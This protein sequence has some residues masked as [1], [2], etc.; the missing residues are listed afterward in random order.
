[1]Q[2]EGGYVCGEDE[3][4]RLKRLMWPDPNNHIPSLDV[5]AKPASHIANLA[6][7]SVPEGCGFLIVEET[8]V[9]EQYPFSGEKLSSVLTLYKYEGAIDNA[10]DQV[11]VITDYQGQGHTCGIHTSSDENALSLALRSKTGRVLINQNLNEGAGSL[12]NGLPY[13]LSLSCGT[14]GG[15]ITTE[16]V[17]ARHMVNLT[18]VSRPLKPRALDENELFSAHWEKYQR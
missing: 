10:I 9:G 5:I 4:A 1:L 15:N 7:I 6:G 3:K 14:W 2:K 16:N 18:W 13:T 11:N 12:R 17:N 8:G